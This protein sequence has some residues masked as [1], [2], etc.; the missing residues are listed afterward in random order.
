LYQSTIAGS[1]PS[2]RL[3]DNEEFAAP[4]TVRYNA[5]YLPIAFSEKI[6]QI[7]SLSSRK[8]K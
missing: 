1:F 2:F 5:D 6:K 8:M 3:L 7:F 4:N